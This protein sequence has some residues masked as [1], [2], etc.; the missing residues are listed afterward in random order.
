MNVLSLF[1]G[2]GGLDLGLEWAG[3]KTIAFVERDASCQH[4][5]AQHWPGVPIHGDIHT[6]SGVPLRGS[7]ELVCGGF[8]CQPFSVAGKQK[9]TEDERHLWPEMSRI[10]REVRPRWVLAENVPG[11]RTIAADLVLEDLEGQGY[12]CWPL[13]VGADDVGAPHRRKRVWIIARRLG[14]PAV[15][16]CDGRIT[17][18]PEI[19]WDLLESISGASGVADSRSSGWISREPNSHARQRD[20][21]RSCSLADASRDAGGQ[22]EDGGADRERARESG[23]EVMANAA[24]RGFGADRKPSRDAGYVDLCEPPVGSPTGPG[25]ERHRPDAGEPQESEPRHAMRW[26][27]RPGEPQHPWEA[28]RMAY[29][30]RQRRGGRSMEASAGNRP[31]P[32]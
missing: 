9:G 22:P 8:P 3:F 16:R 2:I 4:W 24:G 5:L 30:E 21:S 1:A 25:L 28:P 18:S 7:V 6:F 20:T 11:L 27:S 29:T 15:E 26:P 10:I 23:H 19:G 31:E 12:T 17:G 14:D 32:Q 13:V